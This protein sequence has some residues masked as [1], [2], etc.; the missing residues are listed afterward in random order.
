MLQKSLLLAARRWIHFRARAR[1]YLA[2]ISRALAVSFSIAR[3]KWTRASFPSYCLS[4][5]KKTVISSAVRVSSASSR[6]GWITMTA[7]AAQPHD[8]SHCLLS[9]WKS[10]GNDLVWGMLKRVINTEGKPWRMD[11]HW[12]E[13]FLTFTKGKGW[14]TC[15][16]ARYVARARSQAGL[17]HKKLLRSKITFS[18]L[19]IH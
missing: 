5:I 1:F 3:P 2:K 6:G 8:F 15:A 18:N 16:Q 13:Q 17:P 9:R 4:A 11:E 10:K 19:L 14:L 12:R 7:C